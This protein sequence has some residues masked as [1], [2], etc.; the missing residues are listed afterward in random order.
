MTLED[1]FLF[2]SAHL[3]LLSEYVAYHNQIMSEKEPKR[4]TENGNHK[5][6]E[7]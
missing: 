2:R 1:Y 6:K 3:A 5:T 4:T 7:K